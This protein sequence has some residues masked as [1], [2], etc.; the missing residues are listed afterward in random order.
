[1]SIRIFLPVFFIYHTVH[2]IFRAWW[3]SITSSEYCLMRLN[4][5][6][7]CL[8]RPK[9]KKN[10]PKFWILETEISVCHFIKNRILTRISMVNFCPF[11]SINWS[12][13]HLDACHKKFQRKLRLTFLGHCNCTEHSLWSPTPLSSGYSDDL[14]DKK[15]WFFIWFFAADV[16][17]YTR[18]HEGLYTRV[19]RYL[20]DYF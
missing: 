19:Y 4:D 7:W 17:L 8:M 11:P 10:T 3:L 12:L 9:W 13:Y 14:D 1:M 20:T 2:E 5:T 6:I 18:L 15:T 16:G